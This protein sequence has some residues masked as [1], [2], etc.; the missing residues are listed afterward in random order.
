[1]RPSAVDRKLD[2]TLKAVGHILKCDL[3][4]VLGYLMHLVGSIGRIPCSAVEPEAFAVTDCEYGVIFKFG[5]ES[6]D[7]AAYG[8]YISLGIVGN[9]KGT[10]AGEVEGY[11]VAGLVADPLC[12]V[13]DG[14]ELNCVVCLVNVILGVGAVSLLGHQVGF[15]GAVP[16]GAKDFSLGAC[17]D[18]GIFFACILC[19]ELVDEFSEIVLDEGDVLN[20][21][22][23]VAVNIRSL[24]SIRAGLKNE[25]FFFCN[26]TLDRGRV[27]DFYYAVAVNIAIYNGCVAVCRKCRY[28]CQ[29]CEA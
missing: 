21:E 12:A 20:G 1:M 17:Y 6:N 13:L 16:A 10:C 14:L 11:V 15:V 27:V 19:R 24:E 18:E 25:A 26:M 7:V 4:N 9:G 2:L 3:P 28:R 22:G 8:G 23:T 29:T 5:D